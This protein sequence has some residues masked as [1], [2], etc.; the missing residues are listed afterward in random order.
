MDEPR[1]RFAAMMSGLD[2]H[3]DLG[4]GHPLLGRRMP[5]LDLVTANGPLRVFTL[6]H[7]AR[8]VLLNSVSPAASTSRRGLIGSTLSTLD[9]LVRGSFRCLARSLLPTPY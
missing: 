9:V 5:D 7:D 1:R 4:E 8:P 6:L 2:I 3:Y